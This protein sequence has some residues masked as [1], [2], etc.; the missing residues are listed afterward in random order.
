MTRYRYSLWMILPVLLASCES[1]DVPGEIKGESHSLEIMAETV[2]SDTRASG[3][4]WDIGDKIGVYA[5]ATGASYRNVTFSNK[6]NNTALFYNVTAN[7]INIESGKS[8][9]IAGYYPYKESLPVD[10]TVTDL[11]QDIDNDWLGAYVS[12]HSGSMST[13]SMQFKHLLSKM[14]VVVEAETDMHIYPCAVFIS[15]LKHQGRFEVPDNGEPCVVVTGAKVND[16][17]VTKAIPETAMHSLEPEMTNSKWNGNIMY[18]WTTRD[19]I[20]LPQDCSGED[21]TIYLKNVQTGEVVGTG[22]FRLNFE[23]GKSYE[24]KVNVKYGSMEIGG[25]TITDWTSNTKYMIME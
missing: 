6:A 22:T 21:L 25:C 16:W 12:G 3:T 9:N 18:G 13:V 10:F 7:P 17:K 24:I 14:H 1:V 23:A 8:Y 19:R 11:A 2:N 20:I 4:S 15:G 5:F